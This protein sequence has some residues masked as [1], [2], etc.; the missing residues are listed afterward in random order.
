M[1]NTEKYYKQIKDKII[2]TEVT[3]RVKDYT[4]N[5]VVLEN[6]YEIGRI[7]VEAQ[8]GEERAKYGNGLIK[9]Y[10]KRLTSELSKKYSITLLKYIRQ[11]YLLIQKGHAMR[12]QGVPC[13]V[14]S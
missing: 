12:D 13:M 2:D 10:S 6:Y 11:F 9:E 7:L 8:G 5:K 1:E 4:K 3:I 14:H